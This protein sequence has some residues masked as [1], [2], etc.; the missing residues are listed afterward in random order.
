LGFV[1]EAP[2]RVGAVDYGLGRGP[3]MTSD[4]EAVGWEASALLD[5]SASPDRIAL[6]A[7]LGDGR[8]VRLVAEPAETIRLAPLTDAAW[9]DLEDRIAEAWEMGSADR[10]AAAGSLC[11][12]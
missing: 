8:T 9:S 4:G 11:A 2:I 6:D 1:S 12:P 7:L 5:G 3:G 10:R